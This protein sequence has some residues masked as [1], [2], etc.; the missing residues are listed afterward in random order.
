MVTNMAH[1]Q[2]IMKNTVTTSYRNSNLWCNLVHR[3]IAVTSHPTR[4]IFSSF[5]GVDGRPMR[6]SSSVLL[7]PCCNKVNVSSDDFYSKTKKPDLRALFNY[8]HFQ[9]RRDLAHN[10]KIITVMPFD[11]KKWRNYFC[12]V[13]NGAKLWDRNLIHAAIPVNYTSEFQE[14]FEFT[15]FN[16]RI[17]V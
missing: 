2:H 6:G 8:R 7:C 14:P 13:T 5:F 9:L 1:V 3:F 17:K 16:G 11:V 12:D 15:T 4:S 10:E